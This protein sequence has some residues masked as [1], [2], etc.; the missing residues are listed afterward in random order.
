[1]S[2][3]YT[4][5]DNAVSERLHKTI[6]SLEVPSLNNKYKC[7]NLIDFFNQIDHSKKTLSFYRSIIDDV[8]LFY[9]QSHVHRILENTPETTNKGHLQFESIIEEPTVYNVRNNGSS[10][11][12]ER[13]IVMKHKETIKLLEQHKSNNEYTNLEIISFENQVKEIKEEIRSSAGKLAQL[14]H[15]QFLFVTDRLNEIDQKL[16]KII[17]KEKKQNK[18]KKFVTLRDPIVYDFYEAILKAEPPSKRTQVLLSYAQLKICCVTLYATGARV[19]EIRLLTKTDFDKL[20]DTGMLSIEQHKT[21]EYRNVYFG[22]E[23]INE[24]SKIRNE[25]NFVFNELGLPFLGTSLLNKNKAMTQVAWIQKFN[26]F[27]DFMK[28]KHNINLHYKS[29]SFRIAFVNNVL[30]QSDIAKA[31]ALVGHKSLNS[32]QAYAKYLNSCEE[33]RTF[34]CFY[35]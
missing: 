34:Y 11:Y 1:M 2:R 4:P 14:S 17:Q 8:F 6:Q 12:E 21:K 31:A 26:S 16:L 27:L 9:N 32:T 7:K 24:F 25:I 23:L 30:K 13:A 19:N 28:K 20:F 5:K 18:K 35:M 29:H 22:P 3:A 33:S 15:S 10:P